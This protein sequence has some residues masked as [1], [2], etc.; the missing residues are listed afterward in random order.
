ML[1][2]SRFVLRIAETIGEPAISSAKMLLVLMR[3]Y[4][5]LEGEMRKEFDGQDDVEVIVDRRFG[6]RRVGERRKGGPPVASERRQADRRK[7][8]E[9][10]LHIVLSA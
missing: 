7:E 8:K 6:E 1:L 10:V 4:E 3:P 5:H 9:E 2:P